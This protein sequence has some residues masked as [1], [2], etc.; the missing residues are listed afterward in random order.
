MKK[1]LLPAVSVIF[2]LLALCAPA[3]TYSA[4]P[5][6]VPSGAARCG[7]D[8]LR[9]EI[10]R[11]EVHEWDDADGTHWTQ[12][13]TWYRIWT[14][15]PGFDSDVHFTKLHTKVCFNKL[16]EAARLLK[17]GAA[18]NA[19]DGIFTPLHAAV[20]FNNVEAARLLLSYGADMTAKLDPGC[21]LFKPGDVHDAIDLAHRLHSPV[22]EVFRAIID[23]KTS[24][25]QRDPVWR[26]KG[27]RSLPNNLYRAMKAAERLVSDGKKVVV[28]VP[29]NGKH[30][31]PR[32]V[33]LTEGLKRI[34]SGRK[35][36]HHNDG[37]IH[38]NNDNVLPVKL[39][40][41]LNLNERYYTE[42]VVNRPSADDA[43]AERIVIGADGDVWF[44]DDHYETFTRVDE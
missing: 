18:V 20:N 23:E 5:P 38:S 30:S 36:K 22:E 43:G 39:D 8:V 28:T 25:Y 7:G 16:D 33:D 4:P 37:T 17:N 14:Q 11:E 15:I 29:P 34:A 19:S 27:S 2:V 42:F 40:E 35:D 9:I 12:K 24:E 1:H 31:K 21:D 13:I 41:E 6:I 32:E 10:I 26:G 44:T 3:R